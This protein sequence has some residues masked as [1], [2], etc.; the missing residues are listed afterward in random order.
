MGTE[1]KGSIGGKRETSVS[2]T[3]TTTKNFFKFLKII[4]VNLEHRW[5][6][7]MSNKMVMVLLHMYPSSPPLGA[8][9]II[10]LP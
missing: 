8:F 5:V 2:F 4:G 3:T 9:P 1:R 7:K 6:S 10:Q